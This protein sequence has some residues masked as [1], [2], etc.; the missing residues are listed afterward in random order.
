MGCVDIEAI[1]DVRIL[2]H[3][4]HTNPA[5]YCSKNTAHPNPEFTAPR[6]SKVIKPFWQDQ[7]TRRS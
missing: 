1:E 2:I 7:K 5:N 4:I 3:H 6:S